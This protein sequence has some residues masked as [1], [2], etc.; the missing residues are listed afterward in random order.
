LSATAALLKLQDKK[1]QLVTRDLH[2]QR[3]DYLP[4]VAAAGQVAQTMWELQQ[5]DQAVVQAAIKAELAEAAQ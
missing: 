3:L 5:V 1:V 2:R 4:Q